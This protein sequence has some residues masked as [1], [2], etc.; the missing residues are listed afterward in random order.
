MINPEK[1]NQIVEDVLGMLPEGVKNIPADVQQHIKAGLNQALNKMDV[2]TREEFDVQVK[3]LE[4]TRA[5]LDALEQQ[6]SQMGAV[7]SQ[8]ESDA[9]K[10]SAE[11]GDQDLG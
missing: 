7:S 4:K 8:S 11:D 9:S 10:G 1:I 6:L 5:K 2:V 3:V